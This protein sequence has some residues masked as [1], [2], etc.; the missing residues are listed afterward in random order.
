M[1]DD[2]LQPTTCVGCGDLLKVPYGAPSICPICLHMVQERGE[3][4]K[5]GSAAV[6][7]A[8]EMIETEFCNLCGPVATNLCKVLA[9]EIH[10]LRG[11]K[12]TT[13]Q[14]IHCSHCGEEAAEDEVYK[15][16]ICGKIGLCANCLEEW[17][18]WCEVDQIEH[19]EDVDGE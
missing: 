16:E 11:T 12:P 18:H 14:L 9:D 5:E 15:C 7:A 1:I 17:K 6:A 19:E 2:S 3:I 4:L 13:P 10:R 8:L